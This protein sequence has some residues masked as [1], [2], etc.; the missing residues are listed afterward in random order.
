M[1]QW[2][3]LSQAPCWYFILSLFTAYVTDRAVTDPSAEMLLL[4]LHSLESS[5]LPT[6]C[7]LLL[8]RN[9]WIFG[10]KIKSF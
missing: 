7:S 1:C 4:H 10:Y 8:G 2:L 6:Q 9:L 5:S 3:V